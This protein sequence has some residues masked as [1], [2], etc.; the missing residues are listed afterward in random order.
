MLQVKK[1]PDT[2][3]TSNRYLTVVS[4]PKEAFSA[5]KKLQIV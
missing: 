1:R 4:L 2:K 3:K 5:I